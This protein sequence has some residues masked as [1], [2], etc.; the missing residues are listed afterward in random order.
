V[1][2]QRRKES[3]AFVPDAQCSEMTLPLSLAWDVWPCMSIRVA[4]LLVWPC[5]S[6]RVVVLLVWPCMAMY[7]DSC[8]GVACM[9]LYCQFVVDLCCNVAC[10]DLYCQ[11]FV[12]SCCGFI[13]GPTRFRFALRHLNGLC[14]DKYRFLCG[15][16][17]VRGPFHCQSDV[18]V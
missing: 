17:Y 18:V 15:L 1:P 11:F 8:C 4:A 13:S 14:I 9:A 12:D 7:V 16:L 3:C 6:I 10:L 2:A 5:M